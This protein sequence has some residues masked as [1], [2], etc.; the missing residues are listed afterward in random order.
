MTTSRGK[1]VGKGNYPVS[2][3]QA[4]QTGKISPR[5]IGDGRRETRSASKKKRTIHHGRGEAGES[6]VEVQLEG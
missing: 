6:S 2:L 3:C 1:F 5:Q 4:G